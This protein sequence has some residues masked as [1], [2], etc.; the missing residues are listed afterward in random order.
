MIGFNGMGSDRCEVLLG[1]HCGVVLA[2]YSREGIL[3]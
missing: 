1:K 2:Y 3:L